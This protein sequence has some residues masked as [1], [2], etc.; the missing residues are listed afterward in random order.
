MQIPIFLKMPTW[1]W[2]LNKNWVQ[3]LKNLKSSSDLKHGKDN[4]YHGDQ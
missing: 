4:G 3:F 2:F 1:G